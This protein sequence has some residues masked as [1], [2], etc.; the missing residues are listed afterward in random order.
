MVTMVTPIIASF[1]GTR[2]KSSSSIIIQHHMQHEQ[3]A[4]LSR[5]HLSDD[6]PVEERQALIALYDATG[7]ATGSWYNTSGWNTAASVCSWYGIVC[8]SISQ[9]SQHVTGIELV[10][11]G[12]NG[13]LVSLC[14]L[15]S[16]SSLELA[17]NAITGQLSSLCCH[18]ELNMLNMGGCQLNGEVPSCLPSSLSRLEYFDISNNELLRGSLMPLDNMTTL[19]FVGVHGNR[20]SG[21]LPSMNGLAN[22]RSFVVSG[23]GLIGS[24]PAGLCHWISLSSIYVSDTSLTDTIPSCVSTLPKLTNV[25]IVRN[26][27]NGTCP[28]FGSNIT[29]LHLAKNRLDGSLPDFMDRP[30]L[31][32]VSLD[33]NRFTGTFP[34]LQNLPL[35]QSLSLRGNNITGNVTISNTLPSLSTLDVSWNQL[36]GLH[37]RTLD[38]LPSINSLDVSHNLFTSLPGVKTSSS[39]DHLLANGNPLNWFFAVDV[40]CPSLL[41]APTLLSLHLNSTGLRGWLPRVFECLHDSRMDGLIQLD[42][43]YNHLTLPVHQGDELDECASSVPYPR[44]L[45]SLVSVN[46]AS[47]ELVSWRL[48]TYMITPHDALADFCLVQLT[49]VNMAYLDVRL[50][51]L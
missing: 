37:E 49:S 44:Y 20:F 25:F 19:T 29:I 2:T 47:N 17:R 1:H 3:L 51:S 38:Y 22:L 42:L 7:G 46:L 5:H 48:L 10:N 9:Q 24:L 13:Q 18:R 26:A 40:P 4:P 32:V 21:I 6:V 23:R 30:Y 27:F 28:T 45:P 34:L 33:G 41:V 35:L 39:L 15:S 43:S 31:R 11:N 36:V 8:S 14:G 16:L 12:L 50:N